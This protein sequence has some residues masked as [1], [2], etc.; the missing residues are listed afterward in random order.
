MKT[1]FNAI[2]AGAVGA[3]LLGKLS[4]KHAAIIGVGAFIISNV[5]PVSTTTKQTT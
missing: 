1:V 5:L 2:A 3:Y 4:L